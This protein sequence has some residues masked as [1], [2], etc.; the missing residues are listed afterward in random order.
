MKLHT[1]SLSAISTLLFD[2]DGT[3]VD[4]ATSSFLT[5]QKALE[6]V[7][8]RFTRDHFDEHFTPD[9]HRMYEAV[10]V[11]AEKFNE[12][13]AAWKRSYPCVTYGCV[14]GAREVLT[15][16]HQ[17]GYQL[18]VVTS[19]SR[20]RLQPEIADFGL[21]GLFDVLICN[22]DVTRRKPDP[23]GL[24]KAAAALGCDA[25]CCAYVGDVPE[26]ILAG[27][28]ARMTTVGV[29]SFY[30]TSRKLADCGPDLNLDSLADLLKHFQQRT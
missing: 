18:G 28:N 19:G 24:I 17:R 26:D 13:D 12:A 14:D 30:P 20:W 29:R 4:S 7:G 21:E 11:P 6:E 15:T 10:G 22:E 1:P 3:V 16:L 9:W 2:W 5:F 8:I 23:E 27:R 25:G